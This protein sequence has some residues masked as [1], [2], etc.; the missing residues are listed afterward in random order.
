M[1]ESEN[2]MSNPQTAKPSSLL[3][4]DR[5]F[6]WYIGN[7]VVSFLGDQFSIIALPWLVLKMTGDALIVGTVLAVISVPRA[8]FIFIGGALVDRYS[9]KRVLM[10]T[11]YANMVLL[12]VSAILVLTNSLSLWMIYALSLGIGLASA[13]GFPS[14]S[15]IIT[16]VVAPAQLAMANR[17]LMSLRQLTYFLGP[18]LAGVLIVWLGDGGGTA[19]SVGLGLAFLLDA[20]SFGLSAWMLSHVEMLTAKDASP[21]AGPSRQHVLKSVAEGFSSCWNDKVLRACLLYWPA[22]ALLITGPTQVAVPVLADTL[23]PHAGAAAFGLMVGAHGAGTLG[24]MILSGIKP[25]LRAGSLGT[26]LLLTDGLIGLLFILL[27][28]ISSPWQ[29]AGLLFL[30]GLLAGFMQVSVLTWM[31]R[32]VAPAMVG[33]AMSIF[34]FIFMGLPPIFAAV[35][36]WVMQSVALEILFAGCGILRIL[37]VMVAFT[38]SQMRSVS[39]TAI[40]GQTPLSG[41]KQNAGAN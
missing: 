11:K 24:G 7:A 20:I 21:A 15:A 14:A 5:N 10:I 37:T 34:I 30:I 13:F 16:H 19:N 41:D 29:G 12:A 9:P 4:R 26:T 8:L 18:L 40:G 32:R 27:G 31:Q 38:T 17:V 28:L 35:T 1:H 3:L 36:G 39:D 33:R 25:N 23:A 22:T 2:G 6:R